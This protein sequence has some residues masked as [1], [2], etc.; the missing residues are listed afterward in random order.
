[1]NKITRLLGKKFGQLTVTEFHHLDKR[2]NTYW[3]CRCECGGQKITRSYTLS[4]G[5]CRSCGCVRPASVRKRVIGEL[6]ATRWGITR[7]N[8]RRLEFTIT[9]QDA[10][11]LFLKQNRRC[12][13]TGVLLTLPEHCKDI[14]NA[15]L[16]RINS[17][18]GYI[19]GN[20]QWVEK[21]V[22]MAK[23]NLPEDEFIELC[24]KVIAH[25]DSRKL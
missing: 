1:M 2:Q 13:L 18:K 4:S 3:L 23:Q 9:Q 6:T 15:S 16:D 20:V 19:V 24:R 5:A 21:K 17:S 22:N 25:H 8:P 14:S 10:W 12:A 7:K 11:D